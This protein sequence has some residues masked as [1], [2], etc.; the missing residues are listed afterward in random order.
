MHRNVAFLLAITAY[1]IL[2][3]ESRASENRLPNIVFIFADDLGYGDL[4]CYGHPYA[5][6]PAIDKLATEGTRF[7]QFYV[8]GVTCNPSRTGLMTGIHPARFPKYAADF[9]FGNRTTI[10]ALL[11][12]QGYATGHFGKWHMGPEESDGTYGIDEIQIIGKSQDRSIGRDND[13]FTAA[14]EFIT[15]NKDGPFYVNIWGHATHFPVNTPQSLVSEFSKLKLDRSDFS[16]TMQH[17]F[18]ESFKAGGD[19][20]ASMRQYLGDVYQIDRNVA[21][22][23][24]TLDELGLRDNTIVVF[25]SDHGPAPVAIAKK[26]VREYSKNMLGY[27]G[28][29]RGGKH[30]Q[31]EG[32]TRVPFI[33]RWPGHIDAG[34]IDTTS[35]CS[36]IDWLPTLCSIAK[37]ETLPA[38]LDGED[39][40]DI[41]LGA[42]RDRA[43]PLYWKSSAVGSAPAMRSDNWKIHLPRKKQ[44][45]VELYDLVVDPSESNNVADDHPEVVQRLSK[46]VRSWTAEL[47]KNYVK[48]GK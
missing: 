31:Y 33:I 8:T 46:M 28:E 10:T 48:L 41:W 20:N 6:T 7:T 5:Q 21:R 47:P 12:K 15:A 42:G 44:G 29:L 11:Q 25:S 19:L 32:G 18:D 14:I 4:A 45:V 43:A 30:Q 3:P 36:F 35:V 22:V 13:L 39:I 23:L 34:R 38:K 9:G 17:K 24:D 16:A 37:V 26:G 27:A 40:S 2:A 1:A